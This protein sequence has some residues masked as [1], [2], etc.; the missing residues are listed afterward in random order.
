[1]ALEEGRHGDLIDNPEHLN[2][3]DPV[4]WFRI[5]VRGLPFEEELLE[6]V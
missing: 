2:Q 5:L 6:R 4:P 3:V 1:M